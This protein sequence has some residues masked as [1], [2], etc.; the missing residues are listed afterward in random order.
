MT[1]YTRAGYQGKHDAMRERADEWSKEYKRGGK[2]CREKFA[3]GGVAKI[4]H[5]EAT[6]SGKPKNYKKEPISRTR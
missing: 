6:A 3:M 5:E 2:V 1:S 4:R